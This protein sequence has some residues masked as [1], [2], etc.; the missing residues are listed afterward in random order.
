MPECDRHDWRSRVFIQDRP[1][2]VVECR[3]C[4]A[5]E[6]ADGVLIELMHMRDD[7]LKANPATA[8]DEDGKVSL[9]DIDPVEAARLLGTDY[10]CC[11]YCKHWSRFKGQPN[12]HEG[13]CRW[14][15]PVFVGTHNDGYTLWEQPTTA[16]A[17]YCVRWER[18]ER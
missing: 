14:D 11:C 17:H 9:D 16:D 12:D 8:Y 4:G 7:W 5:T 3:K 6:D 15:P 2:V 10:H 1:L 13:D 18:D